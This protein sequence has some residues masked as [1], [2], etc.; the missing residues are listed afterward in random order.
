[1]DRGNQIDRDEHVFPDFALGASVELNALATPVGEAWVVLEAD[2]DV[3]ARAIVR[4]VRRSEREEALQVLSRIRIHVT[5]VVGRK[6]GAHCQ[7]R[8][9]GVDQ[10]RTG[11]AGHL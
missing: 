2:V 6:A 4:V 3:R 9:V 5:L 11:D 7:L 10:S 8:P 1:L